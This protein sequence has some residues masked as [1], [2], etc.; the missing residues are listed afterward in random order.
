M[1]FIFLQYFFIVILSNIKYF[2]IFVIFLPGEK[3]CSVQTSY[4]DHLS[5]EK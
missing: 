1:V 3:V 5:P 2:F 4:P